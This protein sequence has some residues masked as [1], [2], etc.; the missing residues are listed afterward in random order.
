[1]PNSNQVKKHINTKTWHA[2][3]CLKGNRFRD[4]RNAAGSVRWQV[5]GVW[6]AKH[7]GNSE[8]GSSLPENAKEPDTEAR[9]GFPSQEKRRC[10]GPGVGQGL[11]LESCD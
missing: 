11:A 1:M 9:L 2:G 3:K 7:S 8:H 10:D 6:L 5:Y 4:V